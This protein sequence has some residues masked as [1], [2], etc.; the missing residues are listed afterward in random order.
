MYVAGLIEIIITLPTGIALVLVGLLLWKRQRIQL[1]HDYQHQN[2]K[3]QGVKPYTRLWGVALLI[4]GAC[5]TPIGIIDFIARTGF[6]WL[7]FALGLAACFLIGSKAQK[8]YNG[9]WFS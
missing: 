8:S 6:G 5:T 4:L 1:I 7:L 9:S 3:P 2:V